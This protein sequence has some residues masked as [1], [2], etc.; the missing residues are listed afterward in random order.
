[1]VEER[2][3]RSSDGGAVVEERWWRSGDGGAVVEERCPI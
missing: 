2:W 3:W 1:M